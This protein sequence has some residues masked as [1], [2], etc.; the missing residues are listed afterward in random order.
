MRL[1]TRG[2]QF[3][4]GVRARIVQK[5]LLDANN[6]LLNTKRTDGADGTNKEKG[7]KAERGAKAER[8]TAWRRVGAEKGRCGE[9][10][11]RRRGGA[12]KGRRGEGSARRRGG[13]EK[14]RKNERRVKLTKWGG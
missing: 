10:A 4:R 9:G 12:E 13:A 2:R 1:V 3:R 5:F 8:G 6:F 7:G 14:G 11:A